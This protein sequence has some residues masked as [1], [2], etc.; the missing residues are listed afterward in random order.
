LA[1]EANE[2]EAR[3]VESARQYRAASCWSFWIG[4]LNMLVEQTLFGESNLVNLS[5]LRLREVQ[6]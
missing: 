5:I 2:L 3:A 1:N 6:P 4:R